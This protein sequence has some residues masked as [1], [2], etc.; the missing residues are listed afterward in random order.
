MAWTGIARQ[1]DSRKGLGD[2]NC[3]VHCFG[4]YC[5]HPHTHPKNRKILLCLMNFQVRLL[6][7]CCG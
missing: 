6:C 1:A 2:G 3:L 5:L 4:Y 7:L